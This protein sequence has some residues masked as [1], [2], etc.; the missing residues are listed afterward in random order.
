[1]SSKSELSR[2]FALMAGFRQFP[3]Y[4]L[5]RRLDIFIALFLPEYLSSVFGGAPVELVA[6]EFPLKKEGN[7]AS[8]NA[9]YLLYRGGDD[10]AWIILELKTNAGSLDV[11]QCERYLAAKKKGLAA[12]LGEVGEIRKGSCEEAKYGVLLQKFNDPAR[13]SHRIEI[14]YLS[15]SSRES[16]E[17]DYTKLHGADSIRWLTL[18]EFSAWAPREPGEIW[19]ELRGLLTQIPGAPARAIGGGGELRQCPVCG[20][21]IKWDG[22]LARSRHALGTHIKGAHREISETDRRAHVLAV[23]SETR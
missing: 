20:K 12:L 6:P 10:P 23:F 7:K 17:N 13:L 8:V 18:A 21:A 5:E 14:V 4:Q 22:S 16:L 15:P 9:D 11:V 2:L 1:M 3:K 19:P